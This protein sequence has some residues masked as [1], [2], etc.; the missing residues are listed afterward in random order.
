M[1]TLPYTGIWKTRKRS[2]KKPGQKRTW[3]SLDVRRSNL[4][5]WLKL[6]QSWQF[7][8]Y[9]HFLFVLSNRF[10][11]SPIDK[12]IHFFFFLPLL[13]WRHSRRPMMLHKR[14]FGCGLLRHIGTARDGLQG[15]GFN[16]LFRW[17][18][19]QHISR[20]VFIVKDLRARSLTNFVMNGKEEINNLYYCGI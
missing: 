18:N 16:F 11:W 17:L 15:Q 14:G 3:T 13:L 2:I 8:R 9:H 7:L 12:E 4:E 6:H 1:L 5:K 19:H 20:C 10:K